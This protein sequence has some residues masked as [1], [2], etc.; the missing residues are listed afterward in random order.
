[1]LLLGG[2]EEKKSP[3]KQGWSIIVLILPIGQ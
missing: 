2:V 1:L 3:D